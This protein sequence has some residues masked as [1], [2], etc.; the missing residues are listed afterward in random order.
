[1][2]K[3]GKIKTD[4]VNVAVPGESVDA[5]LIVS[6]GSL[7]LT[8]YDDITSIE[9]WNQY[10]DILC[11][12][13]LQIRDR[14]KY[15]FE[16][17]SWSGLTGT[18][19][20]IV[21]NLY[22]KESY[23]D[24]NTSNTEKIM[25]LLGKGYSMAQAQGTL[26]KSYSEYHIREVVACASR[27]NSEQLY[28]VIAKYLTLADAGDLIK[29]TH[30]LFDLYKSQGIRGTLDGNAGEGLFNFLESTPGTSY[31]TTG[32]QQQGYSL[33]TGN[34]TTFITELMDVLRN[35]NY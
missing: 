16:L 31:E 33:N 11:T 19:K 20:D 30:K 10:G 2:Y 29:I 23:K 5:P 21:I 18:E 15:H 3:I 8:K 22:L 17:V 32:L 24:D 7:D 28:I 6:S 9:S 26:I 4:R 25:H 13:C 14:I 12:D 35:G 1:M 34:Y 27:A